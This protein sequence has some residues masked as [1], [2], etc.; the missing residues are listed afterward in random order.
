VFILW[1]VELSPLFYPGEHF[2]GKHRKLPEQGDVLSGGSTV[3][4]QQYFQ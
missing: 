3:E 1:I 2:P 4:S